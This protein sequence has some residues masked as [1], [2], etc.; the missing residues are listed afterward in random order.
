MRYFLMNHATGTQYTVYKYVVF[1]NT[2]GAN[3]L[4]TVSF[5][6]FKSPLLFY[7]QKGNLNGVF[8]KK[9]YFW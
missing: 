4:T 8:L 3:S 2:I 5:N 6:L 9:K 7:V 1:I